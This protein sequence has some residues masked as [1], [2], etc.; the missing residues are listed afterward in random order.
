MCMLMSFCVMAQQASI[1]GKVVD[2]KTNDPL[3]G[4]VILE[5]GTGQVALTNVEGD[6]VLMVSAGFPVKIFVSYVGFTADS[7][8]VNADKAQLLIKLKPSTELKGT[9]IEARRQSTDIS[10]LKPRNI[11]T[12]N[13]GELLKAA[14]CNL[15]ESFETNP[16]VD[17]SYTDAV[18]G[19][20]EIQMLGLS[21]IYT[22]L[23]GEAIPI[24]RGMATPYGLLYVPGSWM[25]SIQ[26]SKGA[27]SVSSGYEGITGQI[28]IEFK[29]PLKKQPL[30]HLNL[31]GDAFGRSEMNTIYTMPLKRKWNYMFMAHASGMQNKWD[32]NKDN[33]LDMPLY[34]QVN[35]YN[36]LHYTIGNTMEGQFGVK[37]M[38]EDRNG[39]NVSFDEK[40]DKFTTNAYGFRIKTR[41]GEVYSKT[42]MVF[43]NKPYKSIGL[44]LSTT[45]HDQEAYFGLKSYNGRQTSFYSNLIYLS[46]A[47]TTDHKIKMGGDFKYDYYDE[48]VSDSDFTR[49]EAVPGMYLEYSF[50]DEEKKFGA[51]AGVRSDY[52]N[53][54]GWM[55]TPRLHL[56][57]NF[58]PELILRVSGGRG[59]RAPNTYADN[60]G[61]FVSSKELK[62]LEN[63]R[64]EDA[65][66]G[67][68]NLTTRFKV[69]R[70]EG[71]FML[72][73]YHTYF[74]NQWVSDQF[75][76]SDYVYYY[77]LKGKSTASSLQTTLT[78]EPFLRLLVKLAWKYDD[79]KT[80][81]L[82]FPDMAKPLLSKNKA[83]FNMSYSD[84]SEKWRFD[85][86]V[87]WEGPKPLPVAAGHAHNGNGETD[88]MTK[89]PDYFQ[90]MSQITRIFKIWEVYI[91]AEN[92]LDYTQHHVI[93]GSDNPFG[94]D[95][96]AT[97]VW[98]PVMGRRIYAGLRLNI[99]YTA[100]K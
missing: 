89:S 32:H 19:A 87:Q 1:S 81:Y 2:A 39:G 97:Q 5:E 76:S 9:E 43:A 8:F 18:T 24:L 98:G 46:I 42:G 85:A 31:Y 74:K 53:L 65:W 12:L 61:L 56:K 52:H 49:L 73:A 93:L 96:D 13:E 27:G 45:I 17:V 14:C 62:V 50:G 3:I 77:N 90:L 63:P 38:L 80:D 30:L 22:Q 41:R 48:S 72:D 57:Y 70:R 71:S 60:I 82:T 44:Q 26:I 4:A 79:V 16:S 95:F 67:G 75:S 6:F 58:T 7:L 64:L 33:F 94:N 68:V 40:K 20:K 83:L 23:L 34:S 69:F 78:Y 11:E 54:Y 37:A 29:K 47:G 88:A 100:K 21:G 59:Y 36:R 15:S 25:E 55:F 10:T 99:N 86:T 84:K 91:G 92:I 51:I 35:V 28:N 66:N